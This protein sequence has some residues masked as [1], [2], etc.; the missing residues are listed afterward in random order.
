[1]NWD[2]N[3]ND[4]IEKS[5]WM[6]EDDKKLF[7]RFADDAHLKQIGDKRIEKYR[8]DLCIANSMT[9][10]NLHEI[11]GSISK[12]KDAVRLINADK[13]YSFESKKDCKRTIGSV[14]CFLHNKDRS[15]K[16]APRDVK[17]LITH[18]AKPSDKRMAKA[19]I[20]RE[21]LREM[22]KFAN[23]RDKAILMILFESGMRIGEFLQ[24]KKAN[25]TPIAE[26]LE[27]IVPAGKTGERKIVIVEATKYV[28]AWLEEHPAKGKDALLF[29]HPRNTNRKLTQ[30]AI[31]KLI[32]NIAAR[33]NA[34]RKSKGIPAF[35]TP[36]NCHNF[37]HSRASE[38]GGE[39]GMTEQIM[40]KYFGWE[41]GSDMPRV[42]MHLTD[43]QVKKAVLRT[44]GRA[45]K[46]EET[47]IITSKLCPKCHEDNPIS[48]NYCGRCGYDLIADKMPS[49]IEQLEERIK[50]LELIRAGGAFKRKK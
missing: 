48:L 7:A 16:Y 17:E 30:S 12:L 5:K 45:K 24:L 50:K 31:A 42:Y 37:R 14:Y 4:R 15:L 23:T 26:G 8:T 38:L 41:I 28:M 29:P 33:M 39:A 1:M 19:I 2:G 49:K 32:R 3:W 22:L 46:E 43:E 35:T 25:I 34:H 6:S 47:K 20:K 13:T 36:I 27:V 10:K 40:D 9:G 11:I 21:E 18:K 44:Y